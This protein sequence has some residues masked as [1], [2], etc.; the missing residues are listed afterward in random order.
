MAIV[1]IAIGAKSLDDCPRQPYI[2]ICLIVMGVF[3]LVLAVLLFLMS[4][5][6][7]EDIGSERIRKL[8]AVSLFLICLFLFCWIIAGNEWIFPIYQP[9]YNK[10]T[11]NVD[12]YCNKSVYMFA[13]WLTIGICI[14]VGLFLIIVCYII[15]KNYL[16]NN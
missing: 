3:G 7:F 8:L 6:K 16:C 4:I 12:P 1:Q 13:L 11:T 15:V 5:K 10:N 14:V 9:N 2:P